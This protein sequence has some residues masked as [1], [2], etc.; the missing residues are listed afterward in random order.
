MNFLFKQEI[1][2]YEYYWSSDTVILFLHGW[3]GDKHSFAS[4]I[5]LIK[6]KYSVLTLTMPTISPTKEVWDLEDYARLVNTLLKIHNIKNCTII[7]HSF[8][9]RVAS[10]L[11]YK[12]RIEK[13]VVT[14]GAGVRFY[15]P[16]KKI[17]NENNQI[18]LKDKRH[19]Y[20]YDRIASEDYKMLSETNK[21]TFKN[22]VNTNTRFI[23]K[24]H[25]PMLLFWGKKDT[26]TRYKIAKFLKKINSAKLITCRDGHFA[27]LSNEARFNNEVINFLKS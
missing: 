9:F 4:T 25:C 11:K 23:I 27:Y 5:N 10:I 1:I 21:K 18:L 15:N 14:G 7:C 3:G 20:I 12:I 24:F 6:N 19:N 22:I 17:E 8:G 13:I 16:I 26:A 2:D